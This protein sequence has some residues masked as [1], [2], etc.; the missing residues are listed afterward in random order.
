MAR[1]KLSLRKLL[2]IGGVCF[3]WL[4]GVSFGLMRWVAPNGTDAVGGG[5]GTEA[6]PYRTIQFAIN[7][8]AFN[9]SDTVMV[10]AGTYREALTFSFDP[11]VVIAHRGPDSTTIDGESVRLPVF[12]SYEIDQRTILQGFTVTRGNPSGIKA[13]GFVG[14][15]SSPQII[16]CRILQNG[17]QTSTQPGAGIQLIN[18]RATI[19]N[20]TIEE[21]YTSRPGG[22]IWA[23]QSAPRIVA[24]DFINNRSFD[25][26]G[27]ALH[28]VNA[29]EDSAFA[30]IQNNIFR[31][32][33]SRQDGG[34][35]FL[36]NGHDAQV[37]NNLFIAGTAEIG[38]GGGLAFRFDSSPTVRNNI[39][40]QNS[41]AGIDCN[42]GTSGDFYD[43]CFVG[44]LPD[45]LPAGGCF[46]DTSNITGVDP[47]FR[48]VAAGDFHL[49]ATSPLIDAGSGLPWWAE[50]VDKDGNIRYL[51]AAIDIGPFEQCALKPILS[52]TPLA[53]CFGEAITFAYPNTGY[54]EW[55][56]YDYGDGDR[57][58]IAYISEEMPPTKSYAAPGDYVITLTLV[59][60]FDTAMIKDTITIR[61]KTSVGVAAND[62]TVCVGTIVSF[63]AVTTG[64]PFAFLWRFGDGNTS[65]LANPT[66]TYTSPGVYTARLTA[67]NECGGDS[68]A[69][70]I[71]VLAQPGVSFTANPTSGS[72]PV[73]VNFT[74]SFTQ[75]VTQ[76]N[77]DFGDD[78]TATVQ[79]PAH[80]YFT[81]GRYTVRAEATN[82]CGTGTSIQTNLITISGFDLQLVS[83]DTISNPLRRVYTFVCDTLVSNYTKQINVS[84]FITPATP[85]R[86]S[87]SATISK[88]PVSAREQ[89]TVTLNLTP[90][91][92]R[93]DYQLR[94]RAAA[95]QNLPT[96]ELTIGFF[97]NPNPIALITPLSM[98]FGPITEDSSD[99]DTLVITNRTQG[100]SG[101]SLLVQ[102][103]TPLDPRLQTLVSTINVTLLP[104][105]SLR[106]PIQYTPLGVESFESSILVFA[107][108]PV[109]DGFV[110]PLTA[111]A[112]AERKA[113]RVA[114]TTPAAET[115]DVLL[116][117]DIVIDISEPLGTL[118]IDTSRI[119]V[120][121]RK[122]GQ[123]IS[124]EL[125]GQN[126]NARILF[127]PDDRFLGYDTIEVRLR[128][129]VSDRAGNTLDGNGNG[130]QEGAPT[131]DFVF[132][133]FTGPAVYPGDCNNDGVVNEIDVLPLG[134]FFGSAGPIR[135]IFGEGSIFGP[136]QAI[137][138]DDPRITYA[139]ANGDGT[140]TES[141]LL[142]ITQ[143]WGG[144]HNQGRPTLGAHFDL[145]PYA[146]NF[147]ALQPVLLS[148]AG[149]EGGDRLLTVVNAIVG[150]PSL[151][152]HFALFQNTP[153]PFNP[154]TTIGYAL[155]E[156][157]T[158]RLTVHNILGQTVCVLVDSDQSAG[159]Q[160]AFW[161]G[162]D[163]HGKPVSSG[164]YFYRL[165]A[166]SFVEI[167]KMIKLQ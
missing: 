110:V 162:T 109:S 102:D 136:K 101:L 104:G 48:N 139:D 30:L 28:F 49:R 72:A 63:S 142:T 140:V 94:V 132:R 55:A 115:E 163:D 100:F 41:G 161:D 103:V 128:G 125:T 90:D 118:S 67:Y 19:R 155:A 145:R 127:N 114:A 89:F 146:D 70:T 106:V 134:V 137:P 126:D 131:D 121:S 10:K 23:S 25:S 116:L 74:G 44:N 111:S 95:L 40:Y 98:T 92:A 129:S 39:F 153:N 147:A 27:G 18:S 54:F 43:N 68:A 124:G 122:S 66:H 141:D 13:E 91:L 78:S 164:V 157:T 64:N 120:S 154:L 24:N 117:S 34:G 149:S 123:A 4:T 14:L 52:W 79:S 62:S 2:T 105:A 144:M 99:V 69:V 12:F 6:S 113:P 22:G 42:G 84:A 7:N 167:R 5:F 37:L 56:I 165:E 80:S 107:N 47:Q 158:V 33:R 76:W 53:P 96:D 159:F 32:N 75:P 152:M 83:A 65:T 86:G 11:V 16:G 60:P 88:S 108:D 46:L 61:P 160:T 130:V 35:V 87:V 148:L 97:S 151:P 17:S 93:G 38:Q 71:T 8:Q 59:C 143:N 50:F 156:A 29:F 26:T 45:D 119:F 133:F 77:W 3:L 31:G 36:T 58:S 51:G 82:E 15:S 73:L 138:W 9:Q 21:N 1:C 112:T 135:N 81:A 20:C 166:G 150:A 57:D 85:R